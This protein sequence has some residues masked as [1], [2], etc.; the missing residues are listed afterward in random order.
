MNAQTKPAELLPSL[1]VVDDADALATFTDR[2]KLDAI[3]AKVSAHIALF[4]ADVTTP[5]GRKDIK[6][7]AY[8]VARSKTALD[9]VGEQLV[10]E[11]KKLP[12]QID[13]GRKHAR[14]TL[15]AIRDEV[16]KPLD[17]WEEA[18]D[19]RVKRHAADLDELKAIAA[20]PPGSAD[21]I[22]AWIVAVEAYSDGPDREEFQDGFRLAKAAALTALREKLAARIKYDADQAELAQ[23]RAEREAREAED[24][25]RREAE[26]A[27]QRERDR[28]AAI[29]K[30]ADDAR[31]AAERKAIADREDAERRAQAEREA[32]ERRE[33]ALKEQAAEAERRAV[34][35]E[36]RA[37]EQAAADVKRQEAAAKAEAEARELD[38]ANRAKVHSAALAAFIAA[39]MPEACAKQAVTLIAQRKIPNVAISY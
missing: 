10:K 3:I 13:I 27:A 11:M 8:A 36:Q 30:A 7:M 4:K 19:K 20:Q 1:V 18:E 35:A 15:D 23:L 26:E 24:R 21:D 31:E 14:D 28:Q 17:D 39:G 29:A 22:R 34:E 2:A 12:G 9:D 38:R 5:E 32:A 16:R 6:S 33:A 37:R 25:K